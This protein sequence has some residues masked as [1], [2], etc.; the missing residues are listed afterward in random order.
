METGECSK[1]DD[2][3]WLAVSHGITY[4]LHL[5]ASK[6]LHTIHLPHLAKLITHYFPSRVLSY[7]N[8]LAGPSGIIS[9]FLSPVFFICFQTINL[10]L[11]TCILPLY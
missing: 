3:H 6:V 5:I 4:R 11:T 10:E 8:L 7:T 9:N 1:N 2:L